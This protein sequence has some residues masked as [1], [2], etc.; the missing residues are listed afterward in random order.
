MRKDFQKFK[1][2]LPIT[3]SILNILANDL[4]S[5]ELQEYDC[6]ARLKTDESYESGHITGL[7]CK[8]L[9][10]FDL[11]EKNDPE[12][13]NYLNQKFRTKLEQFYTIKS[14]DPGHVFV[15][16]IYGA[17]RWVNGKLSHSPY[18]L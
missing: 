16:V 1:K 15:F 4:H 17:R 13:L 2:L 6:E 9:E 12:L 18:G 7:E 14:N 10:Q 8:G 11:V 5:N 3:T